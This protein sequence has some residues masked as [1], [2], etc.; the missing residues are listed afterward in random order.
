[1]G[2]SVVF[3][4]HGI[5]CHPGLVFCN[6]RAKSKF[7]ERFSHLLR[8]R[9]VGWI[10]RP[11]VLMSKIDQRSVEIEKFV[12]DPSGSVFYGTQWSG[13]AITIDGEIEG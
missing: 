2:G 4:S 3:R 13:D 1:M 10:S 11:E 6:G 12:K 8:G 7:R 5:D 9:R